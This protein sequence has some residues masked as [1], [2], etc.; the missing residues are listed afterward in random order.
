ME[1]MSALRKTVELNPDY[2]SPWGLWSNHPIIPSYQGAFL[3][4]DNFL[5]STG[6][7]DRMDAW[8]QLWRE[9]YADV[10]EEDSNRWGPGFDRRA[11]TEEGNAIAELIER[12]VPGY[13]VVRGFLSYL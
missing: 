6:L 5:L 7:K 8:F 1:P 12:E 10:V 2:G 9:N 4:P 13:G 3:T 11:W